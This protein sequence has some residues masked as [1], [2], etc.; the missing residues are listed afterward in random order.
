MPQ[1]SL[2]KRIYAL[3]GTWRTKETKSK[4][5]LWPLN[6]YKRAREREDALQLLPRPPPATTS[7]PTSSPLTPAVIIVYGELYDCSNTHRS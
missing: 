7:P 6:I 3:A 2:G 1:D 5:H 4:T